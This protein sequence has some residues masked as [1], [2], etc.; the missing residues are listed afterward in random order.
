VT[1]AG[2]N[3]GDG[4]VGVAGD[5]SSRV[6][7]I[8]QQIDQL[9]TLSTVATRLLSLSSR[10]DADFDQIIR[11]I[12]A[13]P[14][15][16]GRILA[17]CRRASS[18][19]SGAVTTVK[20]AAV[21]LGLEA[22]QS[23]VLSVQIFDVMGGPPGQAEGPE[24]RV[25]GP[26]RA[27]DR[28]GFWRH[29]LAVACASE[30]IAG[31]HKGLGVRPDEAFTAGLV[32]D[33]GKVALSWVLPQAYQRVLAMAEARGSD[34]ASIEHAVIGI[35]HHVAGKRLAEH[36]TLPHVLQ[37]AM[38]LHGQSYETL[39]DVRHKALVCVVTAADAVCRRLHLGWSGSCG[40]VG[41]IEAVCAA[42]RLDVKKVEGIEPLLHA[43]LAGRMSDLGL[44]QPSPAELVLA[45]IASANARLSRMNQSMMERSSQ[46]RQLGRVVEAVQGFAR[47][48][49]PGEGVGETLSAVAR[50]FCDLAGP[51]L[52]AA[53]YQPRAGDAWRL[54]RYDAA[55]R[56]ASVSLEP[57]TGPDGEAIDLSTIGG[58]GALGQ[59]AG[60]LAWLG[61]RLNGLEGSWGGAV[62]LRRVRVLPLVSGYG[63]TALLLHDRDGLEVSVGPRGLGALSSVW[64]GAVGMAAQQ[65]GARRLSEAL[66]QTT[67]TLAETQK[68]LTERQAFARLGELTSGAAH[69]LNNPLT[70]ISGRS[71][72]LAARLRDGPDRDDANKIAEAAGRL[73]DLITRLNVLATPPAAK[74]GEVH[75]PELVKDVVARA[76]GVKRPGRRGPA[77]SVRFKVLE[78]VG[79]VRA[80]RELFAQALQELV[81]NAFEASPKEA[82]EIRVSVD[83][84]DGRL[85]VK[86]CDDGTGMSPHALE[87]AFDA[88]FSE[89]PAGRQTGLGLAVARRLVQ[90]MGGDIELESQAG[91]GTTATIALSDW[92]CGA[93]RPEQSAGPA[94]NAAAA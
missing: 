38:W 82:V 19:I 93:D 90:Q 31:A 45:S 92:R 58:A 33:L 68:K 66:A 17:L 34:L 47:A 71:Q 60:L 13:D 91:R 36:W 20:R 10:E 62:D 29:A 78:P 40:E 53:V 22:V 42:A 61:E 86:V 30:L 39:P 52:C 11:L 43:A 77:P 16:T 23:A 81:L 44:G 9:P 87:H 27:F 67:R 50:T 83:E 15:L 41:T 70:V 2:A 85:L 12:E 35:D 25:I 76:Q 24:E 88:F 55:G 14:A 80:D 51:G 49:R 75:L 3:P 63:P 74:M 4:G 73:T 21:L 59:A 57:M 54:S 8:L 26:G 28:E 7:A 69:E 94:P 64:A 56:S 65:Q 37:D 32:H 72:L 48:S 6:E 46:A 5:R 84:L 79:A 1:R 89:K 18:G